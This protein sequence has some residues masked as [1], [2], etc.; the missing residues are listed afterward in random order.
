MWRKYIKVSK[1][2]VKS[3]GKEIVYNELAMKKYLGSGSLLTIQEKK[4]AF[5]IITRMT[6]LMTNFKNR[7]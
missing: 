7:H 5:M 1:P 6:A 4:D 2:H 3:K